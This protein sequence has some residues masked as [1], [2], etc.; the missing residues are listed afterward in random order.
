MRLYSNSDLNEALVPS[1][2]ESAHCDA[3]PIGF[4]ITSMLQQTNIQ[5][6]FTVK[7]KKGLSW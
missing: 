2:L 7:R 3:D 6:L 4:P 5:M 1:E